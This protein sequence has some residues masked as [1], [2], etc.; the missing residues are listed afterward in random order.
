MAV[1]PPFP[2]FP[3]YLFR[4]RPRRFGFRPY[5]LMSIGLSGYIYASA[6]IGLFNPLVVVLAICSPEQETIKKKEK[7]YFSLWD[8]AHEKQSYE[9]WSKIDNE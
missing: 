8:R 6:W 2:L 5:I 1:F 4:H 9:T 7:K 3:P